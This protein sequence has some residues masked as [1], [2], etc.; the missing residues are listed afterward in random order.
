M[1]NASLKIPRAFCLVQQ[2]CE[3]V[4][5]L[6]VGRETSWLF[7]VKFQQ[8]NFHC[9]VQLGKM[10]NYKQSSSCEIACAVSQKTYAGL[11]INI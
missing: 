8:T 5:N 4:F 11:L 10:N 9:H 3:G 2:Y 7:G 6:L 1:R